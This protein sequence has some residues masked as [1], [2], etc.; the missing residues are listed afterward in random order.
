MKIVSKYK[1]ICYSNEYYLYSKGARI[2]ISRGLS[3]IPH[4]LGVLPVGSLRSVLGANRFMARGLRLNIRCGTFVDETTAIVSYHGTI[5]NIDCETGEI[6]S[7]HSFRAG[8]NNPLCFV[9]IKGINGFTDGIYY[10]EYFLNDAGEPVSIYRRNTDSTWEKVYTFA[11][12][13][14]Y[15]I[16]GIIPCKDRN[17][18]I[19]L[20]GD[21]DDESGIFELQLDFKICTPLAGG[22]QAYRS[23][24]ALPVADGL[25]YTTDT[26]LEDNFLYHLNYKTKQLTK[27]MPIAGPCI[28]GRMISDSE[29][30]FSTS[31]EPDSRIEGLAYQFTNKLGPG[32][33]DNSTH[34]YYVKADGQITAREIFSARKDL[35]PMGA[36]QFGTIMF[37]DGEGKIFATGQAVRKYDNKTF[38][39]DL[40]RE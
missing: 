21:K 2:Y 1:L 11:A 30:I 19:V 14:I 40:N 26:P 15:H 36:A 13:D 12:G 4:L 9:K 3:E 22:K 8:M 23:C 35:L 27:L 7:E 20:T 39:L 38:Y 10:G 24:V 32:V 31:V 18:V 33:K 17:S 28:Y 34:L 29:L 25:I 5:Y 37:P 6:T 16:H